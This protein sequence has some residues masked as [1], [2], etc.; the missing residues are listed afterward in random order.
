MLSARDLTLRRGADPLFERVNFTVFR[1][2][3][4]GLTGANGT[5]KSSL[6]AAICGDLGPDSGDLELPASLKIAHVE[7]EV[8]ALDRPAIE[9]VLDGDTELRR[10]TAAIADQ[11][12][13]D[14]N[15][16]MLLNARRDA[17]L[18]QALTSL[19]C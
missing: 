17:F 19:G 3:R 15:D 5:G 11:G 16:R 8:S 12:R 13:P 10:V 2:D 6:F 1:G 7:Q 18:R 9:F 4:V 14:L